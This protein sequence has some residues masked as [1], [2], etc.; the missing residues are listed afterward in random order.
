MKNMGKPCTFGTVNLT[1]TN[2]V[3][4]LSHKLRDNEAKDLQSV[5]IDLA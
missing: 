5:G 2:R 4:Y 3:E 1:E